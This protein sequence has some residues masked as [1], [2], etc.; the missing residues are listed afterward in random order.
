MNKR[1][2][3][4][5]VC[6]LA[7]GGPVAAQLRTTFNGALSALNPSIVV[8]ATPFVQPVSPV[9]IGTVMT[10]PDLTGLLNIKDVGFVYQSSLNWWPGMFRYGQAAQN[11]TYN[12][13]GSQVEIGITG[14]YE[15]VSPDIRNAVDFLTNQGNLTLFRDFPNKHIQMVISSNV[16]LPIEV[17]S[18]N[19]YDLYVPQRMPFQLNVPLSF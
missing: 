11:L 19:G 8:Q 14:N 2:V 5:F 9:G 10:L 1:I 12:G 13:N 15:P 16:P 17:N 3:I 6:V 7:A 18:T 4:L